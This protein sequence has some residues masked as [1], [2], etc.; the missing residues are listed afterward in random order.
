M[1]WSSVI[2]EQ[3][4]IAFMKKF[5]EDWKSGST[6]CDSVQSFMSSCFLNMLCVFVILPVSISVELD[7]SDYGEYT[8]CGKGWAT[9]W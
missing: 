5:R 2:W 7:C 1:W 3:V 6:C 8:S 4:K 9:G